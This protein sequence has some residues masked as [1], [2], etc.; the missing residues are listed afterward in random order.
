MGPLLGDDPVP[1]HQN[2]AGGADGGEA[3][4]DDEGGAAPGQLVEGP[5]DLGLRHTV[6]GGGGLVQNEHR[7]V[8]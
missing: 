5:L 7:R 8:L 1:D 6:Q 3:V 2:A 4:G